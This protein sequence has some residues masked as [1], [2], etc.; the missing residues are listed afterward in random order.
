MEEHV[1][2]KLSAVDKQLTQLQREE[3]TI[4][5]NITSKSERRKLSVF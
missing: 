3:Q 2:E 1:K 5:K 4:E